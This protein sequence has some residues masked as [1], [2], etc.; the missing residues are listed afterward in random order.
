[1]KVGD[2]VRFKEYP[3]FDKIFGR[4]PQ[5]IKVIVEFPEAR[6]DYANAKYKDYAIIYYLQ[7]PRAGQ[8]SP[9]EIDRLEVVSESR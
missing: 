9:C 4:C 6:Y 2:L 5:D 3:A 1:V 8:K 7:G